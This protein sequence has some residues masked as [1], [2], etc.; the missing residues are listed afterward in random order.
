MYTRYLWSGTAGRPPPVAGVLT[1]SQGQ[2]VLQSLLVMMEPERSGLDELDFQQLKLLGEPAAQPDSF[3]TA[4]ASVI[5]AAQ[6]AKLHEHVRA[7]CSRLQKAIEQYCWQ[8]DHVFL[9]V[10]QVAVFHAILRGS[11]SIGGLVFL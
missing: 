6:L 5:R 9:L 8:S 7:V 3:L 10:E 11:P 2:S 4:T 1:V